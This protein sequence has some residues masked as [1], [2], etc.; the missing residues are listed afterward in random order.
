[1]HAPLPLGPIADGVQEQ[2]PWRWPLC[3]A[4]PGFQAVTA[5]TN[6]DSHFFEGFPEGSQSKGNVLGEVLPARKKLRSGRLL[7]V[8]KHF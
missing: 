8:G 1:M 2:S 6:Q 4:I 7:I 3:R 5:H